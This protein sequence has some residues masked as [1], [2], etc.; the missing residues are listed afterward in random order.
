M[1][2]EAA[3]SPERE[4]FSPS[5]ILVSLLVMVGPTLDSLFVADSNVFSM[6]VAL[7]VVSSTMTELKHLDIPVPCYNVI[8]LNYI[9]NL[10]NLHTLKLQSA[11]YEVHDCVTG[12]VGFNPTSW[13]FDH[14][15]H[16]RIAGWG[17]P[18]SFLQDCTL[19]ECSHISIDDIDL[20][21][22]DQ[23][24]N[25]RSFLQTKNWKQVRSSAS[26]H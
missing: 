20:A 26:Q 19:P 8:V 11:S 17:F 16:L 12:A 2:K 24:E 3:Y 5:A 21:I 15:T 18:W 9:H 22:Q 14:L 23:V 25:L 6:L 13:S 7:P 1:D 10:K 4:C